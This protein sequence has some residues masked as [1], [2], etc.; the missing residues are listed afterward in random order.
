[1][2]GSPGASNR[3]SD[4]V[5]DFRSFTSEPQRSAIAN[6]DTMTAR[7]RSVCGTMISIA[8]V[9]AMEMIETPECTDAFT[10]LWCLGCCTEFRYTPNSDWVTIIYPGMRRFLD[11]RT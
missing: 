10:V 6:L 9:T 11:S 3:C 1:M 5:T 2:K 4:S 8:N 7:M